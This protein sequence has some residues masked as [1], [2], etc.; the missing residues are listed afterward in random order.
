MNGIHIAL[1]SLCLFIAAEG[2]GGSSSTQDDSRLDKQVMRALDRAEKAL[3]SFRKR[4]K[5]LESLAKNEVEKLFKI[6]YKVAEVR[7]QDIGDINHALAQLGA[8]RWNC[9]YV[10]RSGASYRLFCKRKSRSYLRY[11]A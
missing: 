1:V 7:S 4:D 6:E 2:C 8:K 10:E 5:S 9:F 3:K 11:L